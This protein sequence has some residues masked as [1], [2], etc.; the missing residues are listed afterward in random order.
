MKS[1]SYMHRGSVVDHRAH[2]H[3]FI[4]CHGVAFK[5]HAAKTCREMH[6]SLDI[7]PICRHRNPFNLTSLLLR[8]LEDLLDNLLLLDQE[9]TDNTVTNAATAS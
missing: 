9:S 1:A 2:K 3:V 5:L 8:L 6:P 7:E 4:S